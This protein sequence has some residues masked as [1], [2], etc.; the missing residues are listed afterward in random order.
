[1]S[2][3]GLLLMNGGYQVSASDKNGG[4]YLQKLS[5]KGAFT[6]TGSIPENIPRGAIIFYS[7]AIPENDP[8]RLWAVDQK[9][10]IHSRHGLLKSL[11][12]QYYTIAV[13]GTHG[14]TTTTGWIAFLLEKAG[15]DP[16]AIVG[17]TLVQWNSNVR[18]GS[19]KMQNMPV[20]VIEADE[21]DGSF[22]DLTTK[23][24]VITNIELDH[25]DH[26]HNLI[27]VEK[28]FHKFIRNCENNGGIFFPSHEVQNFMNPD[29]NSSE[30]IYEINRK[31]KINEEKHALVFSDSRKD[32]TFKVGLQGLHNL[33][34]AFA[35][36]TF[37][38]YH[39]IP[40]ETIQ[41]SLFEFAGV[42]RRMQ[43]LLV[44]SN[45]LQSVISVMDDYAHHP[46]EI[47]MVLETLMKTGKKIVVV[48]EPHR[49]SRLLRFND[50]FRQ[51]FEKLGLKKIFLMNVFDAAGER[52]KP[53]F[54]S[55]ELIWE[56]WKKSAQGVI[57]QKNE[58][59]ELLNLVLDQKEDTTIVFLGAGVS[60]D[61]AQ[62]FAGL[63]AKKKV[64]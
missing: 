31:I 4:K 46:T 40:V 38:L 2:A 9:L 47:K 22:L 14:K 35:V 29:L 5:E 1:M 43:T 19:G 34:N 23:E 49:I 7:S 55:F 44:L 56:E 54:A 58:M 52:S 11:S 26:Y 57:F 59:D 62:S 8:E 36:L 25:V 45:S 24:I 39:D 20:L 21:S 17:G 12:A 37:G 30:K 41:E 32:I 3:V 61:F 10:E 15:Y 50:E 6:W 16:N 51:V 64:V 28:N 60:S 13:S 18:L 33:W 42:E 63:L 27:E 53:E 48:W